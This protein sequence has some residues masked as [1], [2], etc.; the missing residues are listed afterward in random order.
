VPLNVDYNNS[1]FLLYS[2]KNFDIVA[3]FNQ[4]LLDVKVI[5]SDSAHIFSTIKDGLKNSADTSFHLV[6][7][8]AELYLWFMDSWCQKNIGLICHELIF[9]E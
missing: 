3:V 7:I 6:R 2:E 8:K 9:K 4:T 5:Q 1:R